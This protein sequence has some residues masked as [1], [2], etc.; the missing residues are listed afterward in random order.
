MS[1]AVV[2][3]TMDRPAHVERNLESLQRSRLQ[4]VDVVIVDSSP[5]PETRAV[6]ERVASEWP[7]VR[8]LFAPK[9]G[10]SRARNIGVQSTT[11]DL[12]L[13]TDDDC[14][15]HEDCVEHVI[16]TFESDPEVMCIT[17]AV[18]P[19]GSSK[20][21]VAVA[22][23]STA[24]QQE[25]KG[26]TRPWGIGHS[27]NMSFRR[28]AY[29]WIGG[30]DEEM[31][32]GTDLYAAEDLDILYRVLRAGGKIIYQPRAIIYHDQWRSRSEARRRRA[33]YARGTAAFL[34][35]HILV[36]GDRYA[37]QMTPRRLWEDVPLLALIGLAKHNLEL[38]LV[39]LYQLWG[40]ATGFYVAARHYRGRGGRTAG[41]SR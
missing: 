19:Y 30:F 27:V 29:G 25:W 10:T 41:R 4:P 16:H 15:V 9:T 1:L 40:L 31:G 17:G 20:G 14:L 24:D 18:H 39:S 3:A 22:I 28:E 6:V 21:G 7:A 12:V 2:I 32:P 33:D 13:I 26:V 38:E 8:Y 5:G 37:L 35:K 36:H 11:A 23:K 34:T